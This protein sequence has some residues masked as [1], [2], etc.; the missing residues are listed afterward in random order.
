M[1]IDR[2]E[3]RELDML[4]AEKV[5][6]FQ[7]VEKPYIEEDVDGQVYR[8]I[9]VDWFTPEGRW[10]ADPETNTDKIPPYSTYIDAAWEVVERVNEYAE[11]THDR[12]PIDWDNLLFQ[13]Q[14]VKWGDSWCAAF[15]APR[16]EHEDDWYALKDFGG[17]GNQQY[18]ARAETAP[19]AIC[20][21]ALKAVK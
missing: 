11:Q 9:D 6:G 2:L 15:D 3:G 16:T 4:I 8:G 13:L 7:R 12:E 17:E 14:L 1:D 21:A 5:M 18:A 20:R 10:I 19:L